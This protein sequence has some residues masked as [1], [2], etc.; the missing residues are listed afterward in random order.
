MT[1]QRFELTDEKK[2]NIFGVELFRIKV[3]KS[4]KHKFAGEIKEGTLGGWVK[5]LKKIDGIG[6]RW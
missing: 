6:Y 2:V 5:N 3:I 1:E 4:F